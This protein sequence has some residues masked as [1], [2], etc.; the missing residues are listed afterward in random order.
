MYKKNR[1]TISKN[2]AKKY[3]NIFY[4]AVM[5][6]VPRFYGILIYY[7]KYFIVNIS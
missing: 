7:T 1:A 4:F 5:L 6:T 3:L 2:Q